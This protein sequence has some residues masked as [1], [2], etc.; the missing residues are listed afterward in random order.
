MRSLPIVELAS[1]RRLQNR[2]APWIH[3]GRLILVALLLLGLHRWARVQSSIARPTEAQ[4]I[5]VAAVQTL[6]PGSESMEPLEHDPAVVRVADAAG[7][8]LGFVAQTLPHAERH[9][10]IFGRLEALAAGATLVIRNDHDPRPLRYQTESLWPGAYDWS[11]LEAGPEIWR[12]AITRA[13]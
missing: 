4:P 9:Q 10:V 3:T 5:A 7:Q 6:V 1:D 8:T 12:V 2:L 11:Y 13:G